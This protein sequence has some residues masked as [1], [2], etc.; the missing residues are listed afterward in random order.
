MRKQIYRKVS[1]DRKIRELQTQHIPVIVNKSG[2]SDKQRNKMEFMFNSTTARGVSGDNT[3]FSN[4]AHS[5]VLL[6]S[7]KYEKVLGI[8]VESSVTKAPCKTPLVQYLPI[9][10]V[11]FAYGSGDSKHNFKLN[12]KALPFVTNST[13]KTSMQLTKPGG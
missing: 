5:F 8:K 7:P 2:S 10:T 6:D 9:E 13:N 4:T 11:N 12:Q 3:N 1:D